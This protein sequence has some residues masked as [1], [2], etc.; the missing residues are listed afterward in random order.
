MAGTGNPMRTRA[1]LETVLAA[2]GG[3]LAILT[4]VS[5]DWLEVFGWEPDGGNGLLE[6][7]V[8]AALTVSAV[9]LALAA[10]THWRLSVK[11]SSA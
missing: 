11:G 2:I 10:R 9:L 5:R 3:G 1:G 8:V 4:L 6:W 7:I